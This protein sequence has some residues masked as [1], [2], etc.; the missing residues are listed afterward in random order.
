MPDSVPLLGWI[1]FPL[2]GQNPF[3]PYGPLE[4]VVVI[5]PWGLSLDTPSLVRGYPLTLLSAYEKGTGKTQTFESGYFPV[6][7]DVL[8]SIERVLVPPKK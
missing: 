4:I 2:R 3:Q 6:G 8:T 1:D 7:E 5:G